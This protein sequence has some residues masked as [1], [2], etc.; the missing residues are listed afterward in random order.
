MVFHFATTL[1]LYANIDLFIMKED[2]F[3]VR[4]SVS[5]YKARYLKWFDRKPEDLFPAY[6]DLCW[7]IIDNLFKGEL[8]WKT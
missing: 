2:R 7:D 4:N 1:I 6:Q 5:E 3:E 8:K